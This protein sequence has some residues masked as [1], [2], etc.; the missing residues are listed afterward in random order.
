MSARFLVVMRQQPALRDDLGPGHRLR[1]GGRKTPRQSRNYR[2]NLLPP[3]PSGF[4]QAPDGR[5]RQRGRQRR[6]SALRPADLRRG[7]EGRTD[8]PVIKTLIL[9]YS[10]VTTHPLGPPLC[11]GSYP[12]SPCQLSRK[13]GDERLKLKPKFYNHPFPLPLFAESVFS[14]SF[15]VTQVRSSY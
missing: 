3:R 2:Y 15:D 10:A 4:E 11:S 1:L 5:Q 7:G 6:D 9:D 8:H 12:L 14:V 13:E